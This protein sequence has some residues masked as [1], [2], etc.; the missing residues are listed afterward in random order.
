MGTGA[1][2]VLAALRCRVPLGLDPL[3]DWGAFYATSAERVGEDAEPLAVPSARSFGSAL[4]RT[5]MRGHS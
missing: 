5:R 1:S 4:Y 3:A 2:T